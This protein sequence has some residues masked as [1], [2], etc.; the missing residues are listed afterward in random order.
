[1]EKE[2][3][4]IRS[5]ITRSCPCDSAPLASCPSRIQS[6]SSSARRSC[7]TT[8]RPIFSSARVL[9]RRARDEGRVREEPA[10]AREA[11]SPRGGARWAPGTRDRETAIAGRFLDVS[12]LCARNVVPAQA[13]VSV[14]RGRLSRALGQSSSYPWALSLGRG[15]RTPAG[16]HT[17]ARRGDCPLRAERRPCAGVSVRCTRTPV[18]VHGAVVIVPADG[19]RSAGNA[20]RG[21]R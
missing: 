21:Q 6:V 3:G 7:V 13:S 19:R 18:P 14:V 20:D 17:F 8:S 1:M 5:R 15:R 16:G 9:P 10:G 2:P 4:S 12:H 11:C